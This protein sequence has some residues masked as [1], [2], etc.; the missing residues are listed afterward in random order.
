MWRRWWPR[1]QQRGDR[2]SAVPEPGDGHEP[3][4]CGDAPPR[5]PHPH[6]AGHPDPPR[7]I[8]GRLVPRL[9]FLV[10]TPR[11]GVSVACPSVPRGVPPVGHASDLALRRSAVA[12]SIEPGRFICWRRVPSSTIA[13]P[14]EMVEWCPACHAR[15]AL[16]PHRSPVKRSDI[17]LEKV[18]DLTG[19]VCR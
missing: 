16:V 19:S 8:A 13:H 2:Q 15:P 6:P 11:S 17:A 14:V 9:R 5:H 4:R 7:P 3:S 1:P 18:E 10:P 12:L